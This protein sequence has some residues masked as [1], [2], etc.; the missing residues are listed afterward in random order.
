M[1]GE[2]ALLKRIFLRHK[3]P[4]FLFQ[5]RPS[6]TDKSS[7]SEDSGDSELV[8][9]E[10]TERTEILAGLKKRT[11]VS[12]EEERL[13]DVGLTSGSLSETSCVKVDRNYLN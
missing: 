12:S 4:K 6:D 8:L 5:E 1:C 7:N 11:V 10:K 3:K 9:Y 13:I 2:K